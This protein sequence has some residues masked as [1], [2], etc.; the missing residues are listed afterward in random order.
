VSAV[1]ANQ[2]SVDE[3]RGTV[4]ITMS[5]QTSGATATQ[6]RSAPVA[7]GET[8]TLPQAVFGVKPGTFYVLRVTVLLPADQAVTDGTVFQ[9]TLQIA[10]GT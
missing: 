2:G 10:P 1:L 9:E 7:V 6:V 5:D 8:V 4:R 3:P